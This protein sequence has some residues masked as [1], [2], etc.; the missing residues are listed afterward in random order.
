MELLLGLLNYSACDKMTYLISCK[1][2]KISLIELEKPENYD[3]I[4]R[5]KK[6][7]DE[8]ML[9]GIGGMLSVISSFIIIIGYTAILSTVKW[10]FSLVAIVCSIPYILYTL[11]QGKTA[12]NT[13]KELNNVIRKEE[14]INTVLTDRRDAKDI[15]LYKLVKYFEKKAQDLR[16]IVYFKTQKLNF[17]ILRETLLTNILRNSGLGCCLIMVCIMCTNNISTSIGDVMLLISATKGITLYMERFIDNISTI[18][19]FVYYV[20]DWKAFK[21]LPEEENGNEEINEFNIVFKNVFFKYYNASENTLKGIDISIKE[22]EKIAIVGENGCGK[23][24]LISL[25]LGIFSPSAGE[26]Y[27]GGK[28]LKKVLST[29]RKYAACIFQNY[30]KFQMSIKDNIKAGNFGEEN[31]EFDYEILR[32]NDFLN[33]F[34]KRDMTNLGQLSED[35]IELSGGQWQKIAIERALYRKNS[36]VLI[37]DEPT[38]SVDSMYENDFYEN[39][40]EI[41]RGKTVIL[42]S[43]RLSA[44][45]LCERIIVMDEGKIIENGTHEELMDKKGKYYNMYQAQNSLYSI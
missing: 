15:R 43:H 17:K 44:A 23:S 29:F 3:L 12:Y 8:N 42:I 7:I 5:I 18:Q 16:A 39:F 32:F 26:I 28:P 13:A 27:I 1:L 21:S 41:S 19:E 38:A 4:D 30:L 31:I 10:Y 22:G 35:S 37:M 9:A 25:L 14:Y 11:R 36:K 20:R 45:K 33:E 40:D 24:T 2:E 34:P 6:K